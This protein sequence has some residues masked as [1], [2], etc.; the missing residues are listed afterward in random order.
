MRLGLAVADLGERRLRVAR[1]RVPCGQGTDWRAPA[2][3]TPARRSWRCLM[4]RLAIA[5]LAMQS[6]ET[7]FD[8][9]ADFSEPAVASALAANSRRPGFAFT[10]HGTARAFARRCVSSL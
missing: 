6:A 4:P 8:L 1:T 3:R 10:A 5:E 9:V 2:A 7:V